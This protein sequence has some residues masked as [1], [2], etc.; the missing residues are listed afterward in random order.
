MADEQ[1]KRR[2]RQAKEY[3]DAANKPISL[4]D[5]NSA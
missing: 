2:A 5:S 1:E 3:A 4:A